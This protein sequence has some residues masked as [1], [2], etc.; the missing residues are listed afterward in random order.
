[1]N[2]DHD[3]TK[4]I[5][6]K[7]RIIKKWQKGL[8]NLFGLIFTKSIFLGLKTGHVPHVGNLCIGGPLPPMWWELIL[9]QCGR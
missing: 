2:G 3:P 1:L 4:G 7:I 8:A 5:V 9:P 6:V